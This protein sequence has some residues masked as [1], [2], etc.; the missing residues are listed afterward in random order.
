MSISHSQ[1]ELL[2]FAHA[3]PVL[4]EHHF[5]RQIL[6]IC[7]PYKKYDQQTKYRLSPRRSDSCV[8]ITRLRRHTD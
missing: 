5:Q 8:F 4:K 3:N 6:E 7:K 2:N 1:P